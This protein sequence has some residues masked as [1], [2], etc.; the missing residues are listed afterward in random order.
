MSAKQGSAI[1]SGHYSN[2]VPYLYTK[3]KVSIERALN[4]KEEGV[5]RNKSPL[6]FIIKFHA[7]IS[8]F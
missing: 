6:H 4:M 5:K 1:F 7:Y 3:K 2:K 8:I